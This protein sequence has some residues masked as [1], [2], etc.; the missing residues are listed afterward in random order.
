MDI[1]RFVL[2]YAEK[3]NLFVGPLDVHTAKT[4]YYID[5]VLFDPEDE[6]VMDR[7]EAYAVLG[8]FSGR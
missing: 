2:L 8:S 1:R 5:D 6:E 7:N 4:V 3:R